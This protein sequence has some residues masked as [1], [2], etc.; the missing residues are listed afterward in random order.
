MKEV[1][2]RLYIGIDW[3]KNKHDSVFLN[4]ARVPLASVTIPHTPAGFLKLDATRQRFGVAPADCVVGLE[5]AHTPLI[6]FLWSRNYSQVFVIPPSVVKS[7]RGR[8]RQSGARTDRSDAMLLADL[9]R[10][11][12][13]RFHPWH[14]DSL[15]TGQIRAKVSLIG[16]LTRSIVSVSNRLQA[17]LLRYYPA[18]LQVFSCP[19]T[20]IALEFICAYPTPRSAATLSFEDFQRFARRHRYPNPKRLPA[21]YARLQTLQ[22]EAAPE[23]VT[24]YKDEAR[25]LA[26]LLLMNVRAKIGI[27]RDMQ[28][29]FRQHPDHF[30]FDSLPGAGELLAP[31][32]LSKF[33]DD[34]QRFPT[35][36]SLQALAGTCPVTDWSGKRK[37][38]KF[39]RACDREFRHIAQQWA[40]CSLSESVWANA[41]YQQVRPHCSSKSH[42]YR[43]LA[44]RW[45]AIAWKLWQTRQAYDEDYHLQ[46]RAL[47]SKRIH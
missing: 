36:G 14:P 30:I 26:T 16:Y 47:R 33:G 2:M 44:N 9:L 6:D 29:L 46:Q 42:A 32:L 5:T 43:C 38:I 12:C 23:V 4:Q 45:L 40:I 7:C 8:Y 21:C 27:L 37:V 41:Y 31:G 1:L 15:L 25:Q 22:P 18:A 11:D 13:E 34:R 17:V 3:S 20:Q 10:T 28:I 19:T 35:S 24:I 39:R